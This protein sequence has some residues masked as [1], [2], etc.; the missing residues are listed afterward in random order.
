MQLLWSSTTGVDGVRDKC[1]QVDVKVDGLRYGFAVKTD[2]ISSRPGRN[3][4][5]GA[6]R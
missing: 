6:V 3:G 5:L 4:V 1:E 2:A